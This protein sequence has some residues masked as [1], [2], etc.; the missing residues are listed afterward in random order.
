[1]DP[2]TKLLLEAPIAPTLFKLALPNMAVMIA[3]SMTGL[4]E[5]YFIAK[6]GTDALA[7]VA[8]VFPSLMLFQMISAGA[9]GG[10]ILSAIARALGADD[11][12]AAN[13]LVWHALAL[14]LGC[15][16][17]TTALMIGAG[18]KLYAVMGGQGA[19]LEAAVVY[20]HVV[21]AG[22][23]L[24]WLFNSLAAVIRGTGN[25][26]LPAVVTCVGVVFLVPLSPIL[27]TGLGGWSGFGIF[28]GALALLA[29]YAAGVAVFVVYI[30]SGR[31][32]LKPS[33]R[34]VPLRWPPLANILKVGAVASIIA[35]TT[36][37]TI[38]TATG[39]I[40]VAGPAATAGFGTGSRLEYLLVPFVFGLGAPLAAMVAT[41]IGAERRVRATR[42]AWTGALMALVLTE[43]IGLAAALKPLAWLGLYGDDPQ[44]VAVGESYLHIV[45][46]FYGFFGVGFVLYFA[47]MGTGRILWPL[48]AGVL[49]MCVAVG[50]G[51][52]AMRTFGATGLFFALGAAMLVFGAV[53]VSAIASGG[54]LAHVRRREPVAEAV[55]LTPAADA[56]TLQAADA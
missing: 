43:A 49:R 38:G 33:I 30:W 45:A 55:A 35:T 54:W 24:I 14:A 13:G 18:A 41:C 25:M 19:S 50:G 36:N 3:Q 47:M 29:Y 56:A 26:M 9:M 52:L 10:G 40:G 1:M 37:I 27:I 20:S 31:G 21:F 23:I 44:M 39:L 32:V 46:P 53:N 48:G 6:L 34:P 7:G 16:L 17:A 22:A 11:K 5:T 28:G 12:P 2:R 51:A 4:V 42:A 8:L 15:G